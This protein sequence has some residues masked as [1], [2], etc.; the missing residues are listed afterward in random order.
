MMQMQ[1]AIAASFAATTEACPDWLKG[2]ARAT[3]LFFFIK[4]VIWLA[5]LWLAFRGV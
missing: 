5:A 3:F 2:A 1:T 4:S